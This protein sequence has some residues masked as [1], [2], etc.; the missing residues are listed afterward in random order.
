METV[1]LSGNNSSRR[2]P[3]SPGAESVSSEHSHAGDL[4][5]KFFEQEKARQAQRGV[6]NLSMGDSSQHDEDGFLIPSQVSQLSMNSRKSPGRLIEEAVALA[7]GRSLKRQDVKSQIK[8]QGACTSGKSSSPLSSSEK[9]P[10]VPRKDG[11]QSLYSTPHQ[12]LD[13]HSHEKH[14]RSGSHDRSP[15]KSGTS[16]QNSSKIDDD[17]PN[18]DFLNDEM[19]AIEAEAKRKEVEA[20]RRRDAADRAVRDAELAQAARRRQVAELEDAERR[21]QA[22][23][24]LEDGDEKESDECSELA[25]EKEKLNGSSKTRSNFVCSSSSSVSGD[26]QG[27]EGHNE[28]SCDILSLPLEDSTSFT[29]ETEQRLSSVGG[30]GGDG[31]TPK[32]HQRSEHGS[33]STKEKPPANHGSSGAPNVHVAPPPHSESSIELSER[34]ATL[35]LRQSD[36]ELALSPPALCSGSP[37]STSGTHT[38]DQHASS[39]VTESKASGTGATGAS[40]ERATSSNSGKESPGDL[41]SR[42]LNGPART[43]R[44][45]V[46]T[47]Y[48]IPLVLCL[49]L[50]CFCTTA[51]E[52]ELV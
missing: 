4:R 25:S 49:C 34:H 14:P 21:H 44:K 31:A 36:Q 5:R 19:E 2:A 46:R 20:Q 24:E 10:P 12:S 48:R 11:S 23:A 40:A 3:P 52:Q 1:L 50:R 30:I 43:R 38:Q 47:L 32:L 42:K 18:S 35:P 15:R 17:P 22:A 33:L 16:S 39:D 8:D 27:A 37:L 13:Q 41:R 9:A 51:A 29:H 45:K 7:G 26:E 6:M 28:I